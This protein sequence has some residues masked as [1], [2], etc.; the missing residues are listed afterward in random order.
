MAA[1]APVTDPIA[2]L[3][4]LAAAAEDAATA[5]A[6]EAGIAALRASGPRRPLAGRRPR[7]WSDQPVRELVIARYR[8]A[9]LDEVVAE[10][11]AQ[12]GAARAPS[13]SSVG[14][15]WQRID[16]GHLIKGTW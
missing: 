4:G 12:F 16:R 9:R 8:E 7:W 2:I 11:A 15:V 10:V 1:P 14:R 13:R 5:E 3:Q 6:L